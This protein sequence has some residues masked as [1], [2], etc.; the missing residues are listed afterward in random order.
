MWGDA[1]ARWNLVCSISLEVPDFSLGALCLI[2]FAK[3]TLSRFFMGPKGKDCQLGVEYPRINTLVPLPHGWRVG[4]LWNRAQL[5][6]LPNLASICPSLNRDSVYLLPHSPRAG[7]LGRGMTVWLY[8]REN[9]LQPM[10]NHFK[11][12]KSLQLLV[13]KISF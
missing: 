11:K 9:L 8:S 4:L 6:K 10:R 13:L 3:L 2:M 1:A 12:K 7:L 5:V